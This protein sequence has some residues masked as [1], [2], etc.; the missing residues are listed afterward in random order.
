M[1][2][3]LDISDIQKKT[4]KMD[5]NSSKWAQLTQ[6]FIEGSIGSFFA[7]MVNT[8]FD[9]VKSRQQYASTPELVSK[10]LWTFPSLATIAREEGWKSLYKGLGIR[11]IRLVPGGGIMLLAF[12][13][14]NDLLKD[15]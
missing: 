14:I 10:Y 1:Q 12:E 5:P 9:V 4:Y 2:F 3:I 6:K 11:L 8:P 15:F 7:T 13:V